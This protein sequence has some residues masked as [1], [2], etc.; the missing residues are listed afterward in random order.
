[1]GTLNGTYGSGRKPFRKRDETAGLEPVIERS[2]RRC[3][4]DGL[5]MAGRADD[6]VYG[7][8]ELKQRRERQEHLVAYA[9]PELENI[10]QQIAHTNSTVILT[11]AE[12]VL[13]QRLGDAEFHRRA[14]TVALQP[15]AC[16]NESARGTNAIGTAITERLPVNVHRG[17]HYLECNAFLTC[18]ASP[19]L[20][21][22]GSLIGILDISGDQ[23]ARQMHSLG[24][25]QMSTTMI[26]NRLLEEHFDEALYLYFHPRPEF[27]GTL[28]QGIA[29][30]AGDGRLL[31]TNTCAR[32]LLDLTSTIHGCTG[33]EDLFGVP[34]EWIFRC[35]GE[36]GPN[37]ETPSGIRL[38]TRT[39]LR[40]PHARP[41][42]IPSPLPTTGR[43]EHGDPTVATA[44]ERAHRVLTR[45][46][47]VLIE[48]ETGTGKEHLARMLHDYGP[49][50]DGAFV[51]IN[52]AA[53]PESLIESE[54]FG[55]VPGAFTGAKREGQTGKLV[56]ADGGT[57]FLDE[58]GDM[59]LPLQSRLL[60]VLQDKQVV[61]VGGNQPRPVSFSL[62]SATHRDLRALVA[63]GEFRSDLYYRLNGLQVEMPPL[64]RRRDLS[65]LIHALLAEEDPEARICPEALELMLGHP[66]PGN[67]RQLSFVL[68]TALALRDDAEPLEPRHLPGDFHKDL[69][70]RDE[71]CGSS[72]QAV[73]DQ[74]IREAVEA[75]GGNVSAA[76][77]A[78]GINRS[79]IYRRLQR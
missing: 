77:R 9:L 52:C 57:L 7:G 64:R 24:L 2:W 55:Y 54:L 10:R 68:R 6:A 5:D 4:A 69:T 73:T 70:G 78:L 49:R 66:W 67:C 75:N 63:A 15:G 37:L 76:A 72:L 44:A 13:L 79:T 56:E 3:A 21:P 22:A 40:Q 30:F 43:I 59:P 62:V 27:L 58:I 11:D 45:D 48:G 38:H 35:P 25:V 29:A 23:D 47:P 14:E 61:P 33:F 65:R 16:W 74:V 51:A 31:A 60:R 53:L 41:T 20:D 39:R 32:R 19:I 71:E 26:E 34:L 36:T 42:P 17:E 50:A 28:G 12:G 8:T 46:I 18:A 1:M